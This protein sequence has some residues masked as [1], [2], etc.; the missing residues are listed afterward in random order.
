MRERFGRET[1]LREYRKI[2]SLTPFLF[3]GPRI[4]ENGFQSGIAFCFISLERD[5]HV[6]KRGDPRARIHRPRILPVKV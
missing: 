4:S 1:I 6:E 2:A 3:L 5:R